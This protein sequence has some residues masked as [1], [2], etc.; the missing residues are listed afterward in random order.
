[1]SSE[2][3]ENVE[4]QMNQE[5]TNESNENVENKQMNENVETNQKS[6]ENENE[7]SNENEEEQDEKNK[8][9]TMNDFRFSKVSINK[10]PPE[11]NRRQILVKLNPL[12]KDFR[13]L[14]ALYHVRYIEHN[15][16]EIPNS[17]PTVEQYWQTLKVYR[18]DRPNGP[19][20]AAPKKSFFEEANINF[21]SASLTKY[22]Y[23]SSTVPIYYYHYNT[24]TRQP[25]FLSLKEGKILYCK[26]YQR[27]IMEVE[28]RKEVFLLLLS[29]CKS[30][31]RNYPVIIRNKGVNDYMDEPIDLE[32]IIENPKID[33][34]CAYCLAEM[35]IHY[36]N[37]DECIWNTIGNGEKRKKKVERKSVNEKQ[38]TTLS[39]ESAYIK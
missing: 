8:P 18:K 6:N 39:F 28:E 23:T 11:I 21:A 9:L 37:L 1:M 19:L 3:V 10:V 26:E 20:I 34:D 17:A 24:K 4:N 7:K 25:E 2:N 33:I 27:E 12:G 14:S 16:P 32:Y 31:D 29:R 5:I 22:K 38:L 15:I 35:L 30:R 13:L 36:P